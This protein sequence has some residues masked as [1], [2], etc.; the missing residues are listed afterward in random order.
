MFL[1]LPVISIQYVIN[2]VMAQSEG[3]LNAPNLFFKWNNFNEKTS[4][5]YIFPS[6]LTTILTLINSNAEKAHTV[7]YFNLLFAATAA[8]HF[9]CVR[10]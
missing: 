10:N 3:K 2:Y 8:E 4:P 1:K 5:P 7:Y 6:L 9:K